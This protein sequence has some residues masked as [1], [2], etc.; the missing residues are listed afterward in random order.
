MTGPGPLA[1]G[2]KSSPVGRSGTQPVSLSGVKTGTDATAPVRSAASAG[3]SAAPPQSSAATARPSNPLGN[4]RFDAKL[5]M[6]PP[7]SRLASSHGTPSSSARCGTPKA[8]ARLGL[9][10]T[11]GNHGPFLQAPPSAPWA[12]QP[13]E[14]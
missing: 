12:S 5:D 14:D 7:W 3:H 10:G 4:L 2:R 11:E 8:G 1:G 9:Q 13:T 6:F